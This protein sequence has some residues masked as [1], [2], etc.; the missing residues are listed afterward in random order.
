MAEDEEA[1]RKVALN[2]S[3]GLGSLFLTGSFA[4]TGWGIAGRGVWQSTAAFGLALGLL[5]AAVGQASIWYLM[6][7]RRPPQLATLAVPQ[8]DVSPTADEY[9]QQISALSKYRE[10]LA[11]QSFLQDNHPARLLNNHQISSAAAK[12]ELLQI[13][14]YINRKLHPIR[15][16]V[17]RTGVS[18]NLLNVERGRVPAVLTQ[19]IGVLEESRDKLRSK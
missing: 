2:V 15:E 8:A 14:D 19:A 1:H 18:Q 16:I 9:E 3:V 17:S 11:R 12:K 6:H 5:L 10:Q 7:V 13:E 4:F